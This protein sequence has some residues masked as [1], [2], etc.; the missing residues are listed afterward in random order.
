MSEWVV[1][2]RWEFCWSQLIQSQ[3]YILL[4][5]ICDEFT[6]SEHFWVWKTARE[7]VSVVL[8]RLAIEASEKYGL[9]EIGIR[10]CCM[11]SRRWLSLVNPS[12]WRMRLP[13]CNPAIFPSLWII[14]V[15][16]R[17]GVSC[18]WV[19]SHCFINRLSWSI[20]TAVHWRVTYGMEIAWMRMNWGRLRVVACWGWITFTTPRESFTGFVGNGEDDGIGHQAR[21]SVHL[22]EG[23]D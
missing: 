3:N 10:T 17:T 16:K 18:G 9:P 23:S 2:K 7:R 6:R 5:D 8:E 1:K 15:L 20:V 11:Q 22:R 12:C 14:A 19:L 4:E 13:P 21:Q